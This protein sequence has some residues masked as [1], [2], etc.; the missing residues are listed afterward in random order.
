LESVVNPL[1]IVPNKLIKELAVEFIGMQAQA[2]MVIKKF[3][4]DSAVEPCHMRIQLGCLGVS[5]VGNH[6]Q[7]AQ[8]FIKMLF[9]F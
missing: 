2:S 4:L 8:R 7:P 3:F 6:M 9:E 1:G 5:M